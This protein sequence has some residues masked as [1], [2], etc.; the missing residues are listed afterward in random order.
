MHTLDDE[1][2]KA[3]LL[4]EIRDEWVYLL[5]L[6]GKGDVSQLSIRGICELCTHILRG[7]ARTG[8]NPIDPVMS[9]INKSTTGIV[10]R[11]EIGNFLEKFRTKI[12]G[13]LSEQLDTLKIK[14][15]QKDENFALHSFV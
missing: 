12:L 7:K 9:R 3:L 4:K 2:L 5:N 11:E 14:N 10:S 13:S 8:K 1:T 6:M 15:K